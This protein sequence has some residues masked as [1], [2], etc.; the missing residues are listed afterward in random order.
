MVLKPSGSTVNAATIFDFK[1]R[2]TKDERGRKV[3]V[4]G[5]PG[6]FSDFFV[7]SPIRVGIG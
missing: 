3:W 1:W 4:L 2:E 7:L 6:M 5:A